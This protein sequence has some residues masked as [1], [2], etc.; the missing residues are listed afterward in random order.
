MPKGAHFLTPEHKSFCKAWKSIAGIIREDIISLYE[1]VND[2]FVSAK[3]AEERVNQVIQKVTDIQISALTRELGRV[4]TQSWSVMRWNINLAVWP[5]EGVPKRSFPSTRRCPDCS[6]TFSC[7]EQHWDLVKTAHRQKPCRDSWSKQ[8]QCAMDVIC[9]ADYNMGHSMTTVAES[10]AP[11]D[12]SPEHIQPSWVSLRNTNW[13][14]LLYSDLKSDMATNYGLRMS[15][16]QLMPILRGATENLSMS[17]T[18]LWALEL[19]NTDTS[20]TKK[21]A[22]N[23]HI[24]GVTI[25]ELVAIDM[26]ELLHRLPDVKLVN[27]IH[28]APSGQ[29]DDLLKGQHFEPCDE[30]QKRRRA[31]HLEFQAKS[32]KTYFADSGSSFVKADLV[33]AFDPKC[34]KDNIDTWQ[35]TLGVLIEQKIPTVFTSYNYDDAVANAK[36]LEDVGAKLHPEF[37]LK[38]N[39]WASQVPKIEP[40]KVTG[41]FAVNEWLAG[42]FK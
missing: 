20:W 12:W 31:L 29:A 28:C 39:P 40:S 18:I 37:R 27:A 15:D 8:S 34:Y 33:V 4:P 9:A 23:I 16:A 2:G 42:G 32:Y 26:E 30:C 35:E 36:F 21:S 3:D 24:L 6:L 22:L 17:M 11:L 13:H 1:P 19:L 25:A 10:V 14:K 41:F 5:V 38:K 7:S